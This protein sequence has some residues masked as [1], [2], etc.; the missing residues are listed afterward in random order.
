MTQLADITR[1]RRGNPGFF[2]AVL[3][4]DGE[5]LIVATDPLIAE[6]LAI[7]LSSCGIA[8]RAAV[9][10]PGH[11]SG[12][13]EAGGTALV[14][15]GG[16]APADARR[17]VAAL[18]GAGRRVAVVAGSGGGPAVT[19]CLEAGAEAAVTGNGTLNDV[20]ELLSGLGG[21][22]PVRSSAAP[23]SVV[24]SSPSIQDEAQ[25]RRSRLGLLTNRER[26]I[27]AALM[28]GRRASRIAQDHFVSLHTVR[29][30]IRSML[31][32][33]E[34]HSQVEAIAVAHRSGWVPGTTGR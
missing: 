25:S 34:V 6:A 26:E 14:V 29:T 9:D 27:L 23:D 12:C 1:Y 24:E 31:R 30:Q 13:G 8:A 7:A 5:T 11:R 4:R 15:L 21:E 17:T 20:V 32:K 10:P 19:G 18:V 28:A 3:G 33:L 16:L 22:G 2:P